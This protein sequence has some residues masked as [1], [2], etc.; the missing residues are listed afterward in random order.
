[1]NEYGEPRFRVV[2]GWAR[3]TWIGGRWPNGAVEYR[4]EPKYWPKFER[5]HLEQFR[6]ADEILSPE[7]WEMET[8][9]NIDGRRIEE[10]G[11]YPARGEYEQVHCL[12]SDK[13][14]FL[15]LVPAVV[16]MI[17]RMINHTKAMA[18]A[19]R[20]AAREA[21]VERAEK[22]ADSFDESVIEDAGFAFHGKK[23]VSQ[24]PGIPASDGKGI[25]Q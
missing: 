10:L 11:P 25:F 7:E 22:S 16:E 21:A 8:W 13:R 4:F 2:W 23:F 24:V 6:P 19:E 9:S 18:H 3:R 15:P 5:W 12:E 14:Q 20:K 17:I 1:M